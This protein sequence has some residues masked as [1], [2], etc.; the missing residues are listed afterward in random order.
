M[1]DDFE[2]TV[3]QVDTAVEAA[4]AAG[5][6][7]SRMTGGG[8]GGCIIALTDVDQ[9]ASTAEAVEAAF[10]AAGFRAP[11]WFT[12]RSVSRRHSVAPFLKAG[13]RLRD[14]TPHSTSRVGQSP[15]LDENPAPNCRH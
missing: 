2:I 9:A 4:L 7:G 6:Y 5:A 3:P 15:A 13:R 11:D 12:R 8:F 1:R 14:K 10:A